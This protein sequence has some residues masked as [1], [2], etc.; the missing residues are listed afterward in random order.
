MVEEIVELAEKMSDVFL[1]VER[2]SFDRKVSE[3]T[4]AATLYELRDAIDI[5]I[6]RL[7]R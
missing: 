3:E 6:K 7:T 5:H 2:F 4:R 1:A